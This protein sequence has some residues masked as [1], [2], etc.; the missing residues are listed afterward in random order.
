MK[1]IFYTTCLATIFF[2]CKKDAGDTSTPV[3][4]LASPTDH[5]S[6]TAGQTVT[7]SASIADDG[8]LHQ[9]HLYVN[10][11]ATGA[12]ILHLEE[13]LDQK[14]YNL[15]KTFTAQAGITYK[16]EIQANDHAENEAKLELEV[17]GK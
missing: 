10:N 4:T 7:I 1:K 15:N 8:E 2:A 9:V 16:I 17:S 6:F 13:H 3:I 14:S 11:K 12:E 5:Q